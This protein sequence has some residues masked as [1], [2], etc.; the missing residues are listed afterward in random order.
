MHDHIKRMQNIFFFICGISSCYIFYFPIVAVEIN[1]LFFETPHINRE[2]DT[3][4]H[5]FV[6]WFHSILNLISLT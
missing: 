6:I 3:F 4:I 2:F 1:S 5:L